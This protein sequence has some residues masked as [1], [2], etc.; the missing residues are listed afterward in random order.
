MNR[1]LIFVL[2]GLTLMF[3]VSAA[4]SNAS[5]ALYLSGVGG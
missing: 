5:L 3:G 4:V 2:L 1:V